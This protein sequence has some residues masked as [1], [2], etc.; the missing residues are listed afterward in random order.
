MQTE[1]I[2]PE[3]QF[4]SSTVGGVITIVVSLVSFAL[5][6]LWVSRPEHEDRWPIFYA[7]VGSAVILAVVSAVAVSAGW[8]GGA[9]FSIP[10]ATQIAIYLPLGTVGWALW[11]ATY[12]WLQDHTRH[13]FLIYAVIVLSFIPIT[14]ISDLINMERGQFILSGG[15]SIWTDVLIGQVVLW[16]PVLLYEIFRRWHLTAQAGKG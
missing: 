11:L 3:V 7:S 6:L 2:P 1:V 5:F 4:L 12:L 8:W 10:L 16:S 15:Y 13:A 9:F 14:Y